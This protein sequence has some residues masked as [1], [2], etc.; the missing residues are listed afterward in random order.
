M[1][2][3]GLDIGTVR[4]GLALSDE[5][6]LIASPLGTVSAAQPF[7]NIATELADICSENNV[8]VLVV[9]LPLSMSGQSRGATARLCK[10][11]GKRLGETLN[12]KT[13]FVDERFTTA[14]ADRV[15]IS[16]NVNRKKRKQTV[17][18]VAAAIM[19][20]NFLDERCL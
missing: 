16:G 7:E 19:L 9:G 12:L 10:A 11:M 13:V 14:Q 8:T 2:F 18:K 5:T 6:G 17:D 15:L 20:Q 1:R 3:L 4:I